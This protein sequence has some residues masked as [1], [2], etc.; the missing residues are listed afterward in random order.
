MQP[1]HSHINTE[2]SLERLRQQMPAL[3]ADQAGRKRIF[4]DAP[5]GTQMPQPV[6]D[7]MTGYIS[8][9]MA[10][11]GGVF[12]TSVW[13]EAL[14]TAARHRAS[15]LLGA[16]SH[17]II[18]GQNMTALAFAF[19]ASLARG[20]RKDG[21]KGRVVVSELDHHANIDPWRLVAEDQGMHVDWLR[22]DPERHM[23]DLEKLESLID[24][25]CRLVAVG[26][27]SNAV[28]TISDVA[29]ITARAREVGAISIIDA[30]HGLSHIPIDVDALGA[31]VVLFSA[32]KIFGPHLGVMAVRTE[33]LDRIAYYKL[34]PASPTGP[35]KAEQGTQNMEA[36]AG[37]NAAMDLIAS[38]AG[39]EGELRTRLTAAIG[40]FATHEE[41]LTRTFVDGLASIPGIRL[42]RAP[43][44]VPKTSTIAFT[45]TG[46]TPTEIASMCARDGVY[47][48]NGDFYAT[49][50]ARKTG[51][52]DRGG[53]LRVGLSA[54]HDES[55]VAAALGSMQRAVG[56]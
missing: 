48:T 44:G 23:L 37:F 39:P 10:N 52:G 30:V 33:L 38:L 21:V 47:I 32:Y 29:R 54:Y 28:G 53:W 5:S 35:S 4:L 15:A 11:R 6:L 22:V 26:L 3:H 51:V 31:D 18:F 9:G 13:T 49:T 56:A 55:D 42:A 7:A 36:L 8:R 50:L 27:S 2:I 14:I 43:D 1:A 19:A 17:Q 16:S 24:E 41:A 45:V 25:D 46:R 12:E 34:A 20:W 40:S